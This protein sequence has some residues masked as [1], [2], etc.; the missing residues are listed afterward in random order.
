MIVS[1]STFPLIPPITIQQELS[2]EGVLPQIGANQPS[3]KKRLLS[4]NHY[5]TAFED[6]FSKLAGDFLLPCG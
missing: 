5:L 4:G 2:P 6:E 1:Y 3:T